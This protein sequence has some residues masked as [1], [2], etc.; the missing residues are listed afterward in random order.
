[1][2]IVPSLFLFEKVKKYGLWSEKKIIHVPLTSQNNAVHVFDNLDM[3]KIAVIANM[4]DWVKGHDLVLKIAQRLPSEFTIFFYGDGQLRHEI[5]F[6]ANQVK[7]GAKIIFE[8]RK[9][10]N[11]IFARNFGWFSA[12]KN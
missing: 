10:Q 11:E 12:L 3:K 9:T 2:L 4:Y 5:E 8:G 6:R 7:A 1:M